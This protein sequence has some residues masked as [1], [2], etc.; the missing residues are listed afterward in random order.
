MRAQIIVS[1]CVCTLLSTDS[2]TKVAAWR[3][4]TARHNSKQIALECGGVNLCNHRFGED[5]GAFGKRCSLQEMFFGPGQL[6]LDN[7]G[8]AFDLGKFCLLIFEQHITPYYWEAVSGEPSYIIFLSVMKWASRYSTVFCFRRSSWYSIFLASIETNLVSETRWWVHWSMT[9]QHDDFVR[10]QRTTHR[11]EK[12]K[13]NFWNYW[14]SSDIDAL[15]FVTPDLT[16]IWCSTKISSRRF[17]VCLCLSVHRACAQ[18]LRHFSWD[19]FAGKP[20]LGLTALRVLISFSVIACCLPCSVLE[21][22]WPP[23]FAQ[24]QRPC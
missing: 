18:S 6:V 13:I 12:P 17:F 21:S 15:S 2:A 10:F 22:C 14:K 4:I 24:T 19:V 3:Q 8:V 23:H 9:W 5:I 16:R 7:V 20:L 1:T 11:S